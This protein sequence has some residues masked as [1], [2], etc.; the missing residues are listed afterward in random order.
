MKP[1]SRGAYV[2]LYGKVRIIKAWCEDCQGYFIVQEGKLSCCDKPID[3]DPGRYKRESEPEQ[4]RKAP[5]L[6]ERQKQLEDQHYRCFYCSRSFDST[7]YRNGKAVRLKVHY[8]HM[9]PYSLTQDNSVS[10]FVAACHVCNGI[11][12]DFCFH[13]VE[14]AQIYIQGRWKEKGYTDSLEFEQEDKC[15]NAVAATA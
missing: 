2:G 1:N 11:K 7:V 3:A 13:T 8:D 4:R 10:N 5:P 12:T 14:E 6:K 9:I 15:L